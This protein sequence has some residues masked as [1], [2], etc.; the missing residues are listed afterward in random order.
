M[1]L[2]EVQQEQL[3]V[4]PN[5]R[6]RHEDGG[7]RTARVNAGARR[8]RRAVAVRALV[9]RVELTYHVYV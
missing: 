7:G 9:A 8:I 1:I 3:D 5:E 6:R 2:M 4:R